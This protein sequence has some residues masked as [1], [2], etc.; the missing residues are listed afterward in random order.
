MPGGRLTLCL[1]LLS[2]I[3]LPLSFCEEDG[4]VKV[5]VMGK[6]GV[7]DLSLTFF[8][9]D[10]LTDPTPV[11]LREVPNFDVADL[12]RSVRLYFPR[13]YE[14]LIEFGFITFW[15]VEVLYL[16]P[17]Q[18]QMLYDAI[19]QEGLGAM[20]D[21][22]VMS[23]AGGIAGPWADSIISEA[24]PN[25]ADA[26]VLLGSWCFWTQIRYVIN[27]NPNVPPVYSPYI[28]L[29]G[30]EYT[31]TP[32]G[33]TTCLTI[34]KDGTV[35]TTY[36]VGALKL[37]DPGSLPDPR[38][39]TPGWVP[40]S[41]FWRYGNATTWSHSERITEYWN[42]EFNPYGPDMVMAEILFSLGRRL[43]DD[44]I[45]VHQLRSKFWEYAYSSS[46][47]MSFLE[48]VDLFGADTSPVASEMAEAYE[49]SQTAKALYLNQEYGPSLSLIEEAL[50]DMEELR[51]EALRLKDRALVWIYLIE[52]SAVSGVFLIAGTV[53]WTLMVRRRLYREVSVTRMPA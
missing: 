49:K 26:V 48:F 3:L 53:L 35:V 45:L 2:F 18:T 7:V 41:M 44:V 37:G 29:K 6:P 32:P 8:L 10:P 47:T 52:W 51:A 23:M 16:S 43:P 34:P 24:F 12:M 5:L 38:F 17:Q 36:Q 25:D 33:S 46:L 19:Y 30:T 20:Q 28:G 39:R 50:G 27:T 31:F 22:S 21:R 14:D 42:A 9:P 15:E 1:L 11:I 13:S 4:R 40:H